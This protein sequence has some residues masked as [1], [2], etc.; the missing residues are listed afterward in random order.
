MVSSKIIVYEVSLTDGYLLYFSGLK[1]GCSPK[2]NSWVDKVCL[3]SPGRVL[4]TI[5]GGK[6]V[7][8]LGL[9]RLNVLRVYY[10]VARDFQ[11]RLDNSFSD[12]TTNQ[13]VH[14]NKQ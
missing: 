11:R 14:I 13:H 1:L 9:D 7:Y 10:Y 8:Q 3:Y 2:M 5:W 12:F 6:R 4:S